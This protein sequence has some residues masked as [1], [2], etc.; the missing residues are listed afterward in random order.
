M[1]VEAPNYRRRHGAFGA[2]VVM[3]LLGLWLSAPTY[4][5]A[6]LCGGQEQGEVVFTG[7]VKDSPNG[8]V[9]F[10][11]YEIPKNGVYTFE[12]ESVTR[13]DPLD[14]RV[15]SGMGNCGGFFLV[16]GTYRVHADRMAADQD[17]MG[18]PPDVPL[19]T[20]T[21]M[22]GELLEP[23]SPLIAIGAMAVTPQGLIVIVGG[24]VLVAVAGM[25]LG[26]RL[27][28]RRRTEDGP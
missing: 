9:F 23:P 6:C 3:A 26:R 15:Y 14:G 8:A 1:T 22:A 21:C 2:A 19:A 17:W 10:Q 24:L 5:V 27:G 12:V 7:T 11:E 4:V 13:G 28:S 25:H 18:N 16:G 20:S